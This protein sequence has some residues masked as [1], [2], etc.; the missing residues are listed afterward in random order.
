MTRPSRIVLT[1]FSGAGKT[2]VASIVSGTLGWETASSMDEALEMAQSHVGRKPSVTL[3]HFAPILMAD[4]QGT[5]QS[6]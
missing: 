5:H 6:V 4:V 1:G 3:M 2:A